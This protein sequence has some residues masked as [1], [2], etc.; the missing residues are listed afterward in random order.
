MMLVSIDGD[1][2]LMTINY[3]HEHHH[4]RL[5]MVSFIYVGVRR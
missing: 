4:R 1:V 2:Y 5:K 3:A